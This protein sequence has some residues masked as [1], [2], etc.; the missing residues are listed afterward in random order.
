MY[1]DKRFFNFEI[2]L[3]NFI[4][5]LVRAIKVQKEALSLKTKVPSAKYPNSSKEA[6]F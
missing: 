4:R 3:K 2:F 6:N 5:S 1:V